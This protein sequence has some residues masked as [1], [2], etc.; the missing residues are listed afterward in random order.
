MTEQVASFS[1][2][3]KFDAERYLA[4]RKAYG[5][6][7]LSVKDWTKTPTKMLLV[8]HCVKECVIILLIMILNHHH[9]F[10]GNCLRM[11]P[12]GFFLIWNWAERPGKTFIITIYGVFM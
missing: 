3:E 7:L 5:V 2:L 9:Y 1:S 4:V 6:D 12:Q 8:T 10:T 11:F